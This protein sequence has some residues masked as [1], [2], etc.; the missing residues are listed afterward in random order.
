MLSKLQKLFF[1]ALGAVSLE[2]TAADRPIQFPDYESAIS[3]ISTVSQSIHSTHNP[4]WAIGGESI[5]SRDIFNTGGSIKYFPEGTDH[6]VF[7]V[8]IGTGYQ[9]YLQAQIGYG[10]EDG[11]YRLRSELD[12]PYLW[13]MAKNA[14]RFNFKLPGR[15]D[16]YPNNRF[17]VA[18]T[19]EKYD[20]ER[21][22]DN[23]SLGLGLRY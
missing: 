22:L 11:I 19:I 20:A 12:L 5:Y 1:L 10:T 9:R 21:N 16:Y 3:V 17:V 23:I 6:P 7:N 15:L 18:F 2:A 14:A 4:G 8:F 13:V